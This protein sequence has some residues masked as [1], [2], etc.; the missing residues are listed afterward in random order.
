MQKTLTD[1]GV[2]A[3]KP[4]AQRYA[5]PDPEL[6][7]H[8]VRV[9]PSNAKSFCA[10][11]RNPAGKQV[12]TTIGSPETLPIA[13]SRVRAREIMRRVRDGLPAIEPKGQTFGAVAQTWLTRHVE[14][15]ELRSAGEIER[16]LDKYILPEWR[17][18]GFVS[19][20]RSDI[21][22]LLDEIEDRHGARQADY[23]LAVIRSL[24][25]WAA[26]RR[27]DYTPPIARGMRR[28][29]PA[30]EARSRVL[31]D[32]EVKS[33]WEAAGQ[34]G[35]FGAMA[36]IALMT[37]Q[38]RDKIANMSWADIK[39]GA[40]VI[41]AAPREKSAA[42]TL[43]LPDMALAVIDA[44][45]RLASNPFVF[46]G[47]GAGPISGFSKMKAR[48]DR[49]TGVSNWRLHDL[50]RTA[51]SLMSRAGVS[52]EHA[53]RVMGHAISGVEGVYDRHSYF[54]EKADALARLAALIGSIVHPRSADVLPIRRNATR[55][56][57]PER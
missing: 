47:R 4:R 35:A 31:S 48:L 42:G 12:W 17:D 41:P 34:C 21:T 15:N 20:R 19:I 3:L 37:A 39:D 5:E 14:K 22:A 9:Q 13:E 44:Q 8:Y 10:V 26:A 43:A 49:L 18:L 27:D 51:R 46:A 55:S 24:M 6:A 1:K 23:C 36:Q 7:G 53:E 30:R 57:R 16:L 56:K 50:R 33:V 28:Q 29:S 32:E 40:W 54:D 2:V 11:A 52:S 25:N 45:P 38:R